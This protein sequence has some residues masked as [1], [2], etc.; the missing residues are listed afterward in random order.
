MNPLIQRNR[1]LQY[2][3]IA[4][5]LGC[6]AMAQSAM[7]QN[8]NHREINLNFTVGPVQC[9]FMDNVPVS[10]KVNLFFEHRDGKGVVPTTV[11]LNPFNAGPGSNSRRN[12]T[13]TVEVTKVLA[14]RPHDNIAF[15]SIRLTANP[16]PPGQADLDPG[17]P[18]QFSIRYE[19]TWAYANGKVT[20][21]FHL[22]PEI[23]G[24]GLGCE[25]L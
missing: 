21:F 15:L 16:N 4:L 13:G 23:C 17:V 7:A 2:L 9:S 3:F 6:F 10:G 25:K 20:T 19:I 11:T 12:Y 8:P 1:Q 24:C 5:L 14:P 18:K 22:R